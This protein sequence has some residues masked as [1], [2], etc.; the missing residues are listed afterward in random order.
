VDDPLA[1]LARV[2]IVFKVPPRTSE[3]D[4]AVRVLGT[5]LSSGRSSRLFQKVVREQQV[6]SN[7]FA[8]RDPS[9]ATGLFLVSA[10]VAPGKTAAAVEAAVL[11]EIERIKAGPIADWEIEKAR[12]NSK[13]TVV[14]GL[15]SSNNRA[16]QLAEFASVFG[17]TARVNQRIDR[18]ARVTAADVQRVA[19]AF[20]TAENR[21]VVITQPKPG[22]KGGQ[23]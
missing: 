18:I 12:N 15:T 23:Q 8:G 13:R 20:F 7:V 5:I 19:A 10:T 16:I 11:A 21:T 9:I 6:A 3:D 14:S 22:S 2:D 4:D 1:R 17:D